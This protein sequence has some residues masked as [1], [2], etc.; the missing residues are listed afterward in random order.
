MVSLQTY[1]AVWQVDICLALN[2]LECF[3]RRLVPRGEEIR[4]RE[5]Q[6]SE[7]NSSEKLHLHRLKKMIDFEMKLTE[8][9]ESC[10]PPSSILI[11]LARRRREDIRPHSSLL[12]TYH[13]S[14]LMSANPSINS[15]TY[16]TSKS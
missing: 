4:R 1:S 3:I 10:R 7:Q 9:K 5:T 6:S 13:Y 8:E 2:I 16:H 11:H 12:R 14:L 15:G